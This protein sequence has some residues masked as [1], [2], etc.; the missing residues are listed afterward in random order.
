MKMYGEG[1]QAVAEKIIQ[2]FKDGTAPKALSHL[3]IN[4]GRDQHFLKWSWTNKL[5]TV[6]HGYSDAMTFNGWKEQ[7]RQVR[8]GER[9]FYILEPISRKIVSDDGEEFVRISGF[10]AGPRFGYEQ[11]DG[12]N[13]SDNREEQFI[14]ALPLFQF[15][16]EQGIRVSTYKGSE[17]LPAG[18][19]SV[20]YGSIRLGVENLSTWAHE[21]IHWADDRLGNLKESGQ[22][23]RSETVAELGGCILLHILGKHEEADDGGAWEYIKKYAESNGID[24]IDACTRTLNRTCDAVQYILVNAGV[25]ASAAPIAGENQ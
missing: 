10:K 1:S 8:R 2:S 11:T 6:L 18:S 25:T 5:I 12:D 9:A 22:H 20:T 19:F 15:A 4:F 21:L 13:E 3:F 24:P 14:S 7:N 23:W 17:R 16:Q